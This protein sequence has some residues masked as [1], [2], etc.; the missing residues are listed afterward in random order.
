MP[1]NRKRIQHIILLI[2]SLV[3]VLLIIFQVR[4]QLNNTIT[5]LFASAKNLKKGNAVILKGITI[6]KVQDL[7]FFNDKVA[8]DI[9]LTKTKHIP[10]NSKFILQQSILGGD[11][12]TVEPTTRTSYIH[13]KDTVTGY[14]SNEK[15]LDKLLSDTT[16]RKQLLQAID[17]LTQA[18]N[19]SNRLYADTAG[20]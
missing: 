6:G 16:I 8:V 5:V 3:L 13:L 1:G 7:N 4:S 12:I 18:I 17:T 19:R 14:V 15:F 11:Y 9:L 20:Q 2:G 10:V